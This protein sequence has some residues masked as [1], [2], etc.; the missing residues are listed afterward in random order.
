MFIVFFDQ[1][2]ELEYRMQHESIPLKEEKQLMRD[3]KQLEST[4]SQ[5]CANS[6]LQQELIKNLG[7]KEDIQD[8]YKVHNGCPWHAPTSSLQCLLRILFAPTSSLRLRVLFALSSVK[9]WTY[10]M[11]YSVCLCAVLMPRYGRYKKGT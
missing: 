9:V 4:R 10:I 11:A 8:Q 1:I 2:A 7:P 3:I 6:I 5:V